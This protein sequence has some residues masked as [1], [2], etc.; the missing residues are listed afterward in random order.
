M[1]GG[2]DES[3][4]LYLCH[5]HPVPFLVLDTHFLCFLFCPFRRG[6]VGAAAGVSHAIDRPEHHGPDG[7]GFTGVRGGVRRRLVRGCA[8]HAERAAVGWD[9]VSIFVSDVSTQSGRAWIVVRRNDNR[10][11]FRVNGYVMLAGALHAGLRQG[12]LI[13]SRMVLGGNMRR[14]W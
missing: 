13:G 14:G 2:R 12:V 6:F 3:K 9:D 4:P 11:C 7:P 8:R 5:F 1:T 10:G